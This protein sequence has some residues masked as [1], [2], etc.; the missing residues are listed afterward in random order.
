[1]R[2]KSAAVLVALS[3]L[4]NACLAPAPA[5]A[6]GGGGY[7][8]KVLSTVDWPWL[9]KKYLSGLFK[10]ICKCPTPL[11]IPRFG[12]KQEFWQPQAVVETVDKP[13]VFPLWGFS[14]PMPFAED[15][16]ANSGTRRNKSSNK[17]DKSKMIS[18]HAHYWAFPVFSLL[19]LAADLI[20]VRVNSIDLGY[21]SEMDPTWS[22]PAIAGLLA[23]AILAVDNTVGAVAAAVD[24]GITTVTGPNVV[25]GY[26]FFSLG[27]WGMTYPMSGKTKNTNGLLQADSL[28]FGR[29][30]AKMH[31]IFG[32]W[33]TTQ[34]HTLDPN[35]C[36]AYAYPILPK[37]EYLWSYVGPSFTGGSANT[38]ATGTKGQTATGGDRS[39]TRYAV[40]QSI[41][42]YPEV[43]KTVPFKEHE[44]LFLLYKKIQCCAL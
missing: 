15:K 16:D 39:A 26:M 23:P 28:F 7:V 6:A 29:V 41:M 4:A 31:S 18:R 34:A 22:H 37:D 5:M 17:P 38:T 14:T 33:A 3:L 11:G 24:C 30:L 42:T 1:M 40:G 19:Q 43:G 32:L 44:A 35:W 27:C 12:I 36:Y 9:L 21:A 2:H 20:C 13:G 8:S 10:G 25:S